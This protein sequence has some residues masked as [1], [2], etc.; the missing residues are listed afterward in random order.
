MP[1]LEVPVPV[2]AVAIV[3]VAHPPPPPEAASES[4]PADALPAD[5]LAERAPAVG[6]NVNYLFFIYNCYIRGVRTGGVGGVR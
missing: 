3:P 1:G 2:R 5:A 6:E 4:A